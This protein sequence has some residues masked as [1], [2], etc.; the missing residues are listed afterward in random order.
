M[1]QILEK[2][3]DIPLKKYT[4]NTIDSLEN[5]KRRF[6]NIRQQGYSVDN[7]E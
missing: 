4:E 2:F 1:M 3:S 7:E 5:F 6:K